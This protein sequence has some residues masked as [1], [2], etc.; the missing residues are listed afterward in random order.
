MSYTIYLLAQHSDIDD[1]LFGELCDVH[2]KHKEEE[3]LWD[4]NKLSSLNRLGMVFKVPLHSYADVDTDHLSTPQESLRMYPPA[5][6]TAREPNADV[7]IGGQYNIP[8]G[9]SA[10]PLPTTITNC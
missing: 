8:A 3:E 6:S 9:V 2:P 5:T 7:V 10:I 1:Q 4:L